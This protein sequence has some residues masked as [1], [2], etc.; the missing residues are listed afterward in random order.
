MSENTINKALRTMRYSGDEMTGHGFRSLA[1]TLLNE[2][3]WEADAI[4]RQLAHNEEDEVRGAYNHAEHLRLRRK[5]MQVWADYLDELRAGRI[6]L[7]DEYLESISD[8]QPTNKATSP[9]RAAAA[10]TRRMV[11]DKSALVSS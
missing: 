7:P 6:S 3:G 10:R 1:S 5:M 9:K 2:Q 11:R 4:E 8:G